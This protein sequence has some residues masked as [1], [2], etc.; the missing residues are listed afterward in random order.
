MGVMGNRR[1]LLSSPLPVPALDLNFRAGTMP[2]GLT[3]TRAS[4][5]WAYNSSGVLTSFSTDAPRLDYDPV[6]LQPKGLLVEEARTNLLLRSAEFD[7]AAWPKVRST[8]TADATTAPDGTVSADKLCEDATGGSTSRE[9]H[10]DVSIT[11]ATVYSYSVHAKAAERSQLYLQTNGAGVGN[12]TFDLSA[13][14]A[15]PAGTVVGSSIVAAGN[16]WYRCTMV[17]TAPATASTRF[18]AF[19]ASGGGISYVGSVGSGIYLWGA[20][21]EAGS[22]ATSP[23]PTT[24]ASV[25]RAADVCSMVLGSW[26]NAAEGTLAAEFQTFATGNNF[27]AHIS[28]NSY[29]NRILVGFDATSFVGQAIV[30]GSA[31]LAPSARPVRTTGTAKV[32]LAWVLDSSNLA[33]N[34]TLATADTSGAVPTGQTRL[35]LGSD[36]GGLNRLNGYLR[37]VRYYNRRLP[38]GLLQVLTR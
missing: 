37:S 14:T 9:T 24:T 34:G 38:D 30:S 27:A 11:N 7:N 25:T 3:F 6:T 35:D 32:A 10:Q 33:G 20:Q 15:T 17:F 29:N 23:I 19:P 18:Y 8:V 2:G 21:L 16:G 22:F 4:T 31:T 12:V 28:D 13:V 26:Y 36:H 5:A 1:V